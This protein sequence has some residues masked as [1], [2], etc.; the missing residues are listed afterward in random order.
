MSLVPE[1][2]LISMCAPLVEPCCASYMEVFT[3]SSWMDSGAGV[4]NASPIA[5]YG[6]A[7]LWITDALVLAAPLTPVLFTTRAEDTELVLLPLNKLL[8]ST[9]FNKKE[10]LVSRWPFAQIGW[11]PKPA[12]APVP[13][14]NSAFTPGDKIAKPVKLPVGNGTL[15][16]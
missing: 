13:F 14:G 5:K 10:L 15:R 6:D 11:L 9:P 2:V 1:A 4:G 3:R 8:A 7:V 12:F 16:I